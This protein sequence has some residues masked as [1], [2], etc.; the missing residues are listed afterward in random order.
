MVRLTAPSGAVVE[1]ADEKAERLLRDGFKPIKSAAK[2]AT[3]S[4]SSNK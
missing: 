1:V 3:S 4:K 2:K